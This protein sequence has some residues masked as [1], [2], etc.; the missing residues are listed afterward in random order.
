MSKKVLGR[1]LSALIP[2]KR[3]EST[4]S[5][6]PGLLMLEVGRICAS[7]N[8]PRKE[9][10]AE[11]LQELTQSITA[12]GLIQPVIVRP[13]DGGRFELIAGERR[14]RAAKQAGLE[15]IPA[16]VRS[17]KAEE[18]MELALIENIQRQDLNPIETA[19]AYQKLIE[20][21]DLSHDDVASRVGKDRTSV[22]NHLRLLNLPQEIQ[23]DVSSGALSMGHARAILGLQGREDQLLARKLVLARGLSVREAERLVK[24]IV[25]PPGK[26]A[27]VDRN[28][29]IYINQLED[30]LRR[31]LG[32]KVAIR[33]HGSKGVIELHYFSSGELDRLINYLR[34]KELS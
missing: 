30:S 25:K 12:K 7:P 3:P 32:T 18:A 8:Q 20:R 26:K 1:G 16:V 14:W 31:C 5:A 23:S 11:K 33:H 4:T 15:K 2:Q 17:A 22:T 27:V 34:G 9:F 24:K 13:I 21:Y 28:N 10:S 6:D 19:L 29:D